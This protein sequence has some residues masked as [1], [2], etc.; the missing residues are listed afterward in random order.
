MPFRGIY[1]DTNLLLLYVVGRTGHEY[2]A[3]HRRLSQYTVGDYHTLLNVVNRAE[4]VY[5]TPNTLT[6]TTNL[7]GQ[8]REPE[9]SRFMIMLRHIIHD[10]QE[11]Y[12]ASSQASSRQ[13]FLQFGLTDAVLLDAAS[14]ETPLLTVD[15]RLHSAALAKGDGAAL[16]FLELRSF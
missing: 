11:V 7:L 15:Q 14:E 6:E 12:V 4:A 8:H 1:V 2:I 3:K 9:R 10:S 13:D 5:V 16:N